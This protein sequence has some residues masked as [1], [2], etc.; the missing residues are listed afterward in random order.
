MKQEIW[1]QFEETEKKQYFVSSA[2]RVKSVTKSNSKERIMKP[3]QRTDDYYSITINE[4]TYKIHRLV[5]Q[6]FVPNPENKP[7]INH[8]N[9][10][11]NVNDAENLEWMTSSENN[12]H[13][14]SNHLRTNKSTKSRKVIQS[15][16]NG[17]IV[18][19]YSSQRAAAKEF[20]VQPKSIKFACDK[21]M[22]I[23][24]GFIWDYCD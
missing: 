20:E 17:E 2:G 11:K 1:K 13:S 12:R 19:I 7:Q 6:T 15:T 14:W 3:S 22:K 21:V 4:K 23:Y 16:L 10:D 5:G 24:K 9:G 18:K 8:K